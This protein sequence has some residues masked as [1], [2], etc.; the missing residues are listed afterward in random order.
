MDV[1]CRHAA[2]GIT[3]GC[4]DAWGKGHG[5]EATRLVV[6]HAFQV[7]NLNRVWLYV[8]EFNPRG[9]RVY[10][11]VGF[12]TEGR[13]RQDAFRDGRYWDTIVMGL[14]RDEWEARQNN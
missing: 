13:L 6:G 14:L 8:Y 9:I 7:L 11:K 3:I 4:K 5:T 10:E 1:R 12:R 2:F